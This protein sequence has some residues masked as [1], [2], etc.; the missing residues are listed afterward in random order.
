ME[1]KWQKKR[2]RE[3]KWKTTLRRVRIPLL[4]VTGTFLVALVGLPLLL[5]GMESA[6]LSADLPVSAPWAT[7]LPLPTEAQPLAAGQVVPEDTPAQTP[8]GSAPPTSEPPVQTPDLSGYTALQ[9]GDEDPTVAKIQLRLT[10][11]YYLDSDEPSEI[12]GSAVEA[13][14]KRFQRSHFMKETGVADPL[15]QQ[16]LFSESAKPYVLTQGYSGE[17]VTDMQYRLAELGYY[18]DKTNGYF[19]VATARAVAAFQTKNGLAASG[20]ADYDMRDLLYSPGARPAVDPTPTPTP[21]PTK[22]PKPSATP[23]SSA[24]PK[25]SSTPK[26]TATP[27]PSATQNAWWIPG[28]G[29]DDPAPTPQRTSSPAQSIEQTGSGVSGFI[30][31]A[32]A[33]LGKPYVLGGRGPNEFDCSGL[34][35]Y[36]LRSAGVSIGRYSARNYAKVD[37]WETIYGKENLAVGDLLFYKSS[38]TS[39]TTITHVAIWLGGNKLIHA[40]SSRSSVV[41]TNWSTWSDENFL[42]AKRVF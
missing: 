9:S 25:A 19:G 18:C 36:S 33:Q 24:T 35:Y 23:K 7:P 27:S 14:V 13:A 1:S 30:S 5:N 12:F 22:T 26:A 42:F 34:V 39:D 31:A 16:I 38:G 37:S 11:L 21:K 2:N 4:T 8:E 3:T 10:E 20:E 6:A 41:I 17:D 29:S 40:S 28:A 32:K 15:T